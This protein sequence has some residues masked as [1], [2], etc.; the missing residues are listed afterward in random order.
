MTAM[1]KILGS[2]GEIPSL[3]TESPDIINTHIDKLKSDLNTVIKRYKYDKSVSL[4]ENERGIIIHILDDVLFMSGKADLTEQSKNILHNLAQI[5]KTQPNDI[6]IEGHTDNV[7][8]SNAQFPSNWHLS[9]SRALNTA[10]YLIETE[11][12][13]PDKISIVGNS[14]YKRIADNSTHEGRKANRRVDLVIIK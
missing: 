2:S 13:S 11:G 6:R 1:S 9:V 4:E 14:E 10:Y 12:L 8:I 3:V 7:I 5:I